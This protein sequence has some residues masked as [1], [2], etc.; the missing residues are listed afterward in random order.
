MPATASYKFKTDFKG[1]FQKTYPLQHL[2]KISS[3]GRQFF[4]LKTPSE[5]LQLSK[6]LI[7]RVPGNILSFEDLKPDPPNPKIDYGF[8]VLS[9]GGKHFRLRVM[10]DLGY[11]VRLL[12]ELEYQKSAALLGRWGGVLAKM[13]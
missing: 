5:I 12:N 11:E 9:Q 4:T 8:L 7:D 10:V 3:A 13:D 6:E 2:T 1:P